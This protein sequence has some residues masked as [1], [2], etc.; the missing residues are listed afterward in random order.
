MTILDLDIQRT[1]FDSELPDD[2]KFENWVGTA[3]KMGG[4]EDDTQVAIRIVDEEEG[5]KL[6]RQWRHKNG[7]TN[8]MSFS[9]SGMDL[10]APELLGDIVICAPIVAKEADEQSKPLHNHWA[11]MVVHGILHLLGYDHII[12]S[13]AEKMESLETEIMNQ[14]EYPDPYQIT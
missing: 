13:D 12:E 11:H 3:L 6:N 2:K 10:I 5:T 14:L 8:V 1:F 4:R 9:M 7:P